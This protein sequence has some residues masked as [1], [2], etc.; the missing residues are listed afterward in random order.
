MHRVL[1]VQFQATQKLPLLSRELRRQLCSPMKKAY[2]Y[3]QGQRNLSHHNTRLICTLNFTNLTKTCRPLSASAWFLGAGAGE[4]CETCTTRICSRHSKDISLEELVT[5]SILHQ[6]N[7][8]QSLSR[9]RSKHLCGGGQSHPL[10]V[11]P[12]CTSAPIKQMY[13]VIAP[14]HK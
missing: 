13:C 14:L 7:T 11:L 8:W 6:E 12:V 5:L 1:T 9:E 10:L 2:I 3:K 4:E